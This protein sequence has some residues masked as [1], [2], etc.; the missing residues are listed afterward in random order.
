MEEKIQPQESFPQSDVE[1]IQA[2]VERLKKSPEFEGIDERAV[3]KESIKQVY[4]QI[5]ATRAPVA[6]HPVT[7]HNE[8]NLLPGYMK[9]DSDEDKDEVEELIHLAI[10][11]GIEIAIAEARKRRERIL[12]DLHD[13]L[14]D[15]VMP[16]LGEQGQN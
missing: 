2:E 3:V 1:R 13:A 8:D 16:Q 10:T 11:G 7:D 15:K 5:S 14:T 9:N 6:S 12:D 4:P